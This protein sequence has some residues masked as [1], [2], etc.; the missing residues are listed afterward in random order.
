[1]TT[2]ELLAE[3][4]KTHGSFAETAEISQHLKDFYRSLP[5][6]KRLSVPQREALDSKALKIARILSG[7]ANFKDHWVDD[8]GYA[9][10]G[11]N[12]C[13]PKPIELGAAARIY[14]WFD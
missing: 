12:A 5:G 14:G 10:L 3:R 6:W 2:E 8:A 13:D 1:M 9:T 11:A 7:Q 4:Q